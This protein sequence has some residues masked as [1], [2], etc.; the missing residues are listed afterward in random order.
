MRKPPRIDPAPHG[1]GATLGDLLAGQ[2]LRVSPP[3][4]AVEDRDRPPAKVPGEPTLAA[5]GRI[6]L[7]R[8]KKGRGGKTVTVV[9]GL[10]FV[11]SELEGLARRLRKSLGCGATV[12]GEAVIL[13]G[14]HTA[15][16]AAWLRAHG[17][18]RVVI[19]N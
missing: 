5:C 14:D 7:R 15:R 9:C 4:A 18:P 16:V 10:G 12:E 19:G 2:G 1:L 11:A 3:A 6:V 8:E 13:Q 17:A